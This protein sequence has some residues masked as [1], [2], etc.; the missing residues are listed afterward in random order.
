VLEIDADHDVP[1]ANGGEYAKLTRQAVD[2][3][4]A[5]AGLTASR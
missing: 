5:A 1:L 3:V 4:A 2:T